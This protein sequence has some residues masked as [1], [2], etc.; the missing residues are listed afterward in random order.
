M[1]KEEQQADEGMCVCVCVN[2]L[3][4]SQ[5]ASSAIAPLEWMQQ[6]RVFQPDYWSM[7]RRIF[8]A[9]GEE[10]VM[11]EPKPLFCILF[12]LLLLSSFT[13]LLPSPLP[14]SASVSSRPLCLVCASSACSG[15]F[16]FFRGTQGDIIFQSPQNGTESARVI[17]RLGSLSRKAWN[18]CH[19]FQG[20]P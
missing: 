1:W 16:P 5:A 2:K 19:L 12:L 13:T 9:M 10:T 4:A 17:C 20:N 3:F 6:A 7:W 18:I 8:S 11:T 15:P 14:V